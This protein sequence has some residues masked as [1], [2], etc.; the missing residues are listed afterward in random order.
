[1]KISSRVCIAMAMA[2]VPLAVV[3]AEAITI[4]VTSGTSGSYHPSQSY[5]ESRGVDVTVLTA[6][7]LLV[8]SM[9]LNALNVGADGLADVGARIYTS[10]SG[11]LVASRDT[12]VFANGSVTL[13]L[14]ATMAAGHS[15]RVCFF[16]G[17]LGEN[18]DNSATL[19]QPNAFPY[20]DGTGSL[21]INQAY[22]SPVD[23]Y[24]T[25]LNIFAPWI[26]IQATPAI[27]GVG[28]RSPGSGL[29]LVRPASPSPFRSSTSIRFD[30]G[31]GMPV[32]ARVVTLTG[33]VVRGLLGP[34]WCSAG[35]HELKWD[36]RDDQGR[37]APGGVYFVQVRA[38][39][40]VSVR[41]VQLL[42]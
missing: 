38:G 14:T 7:D 39:T 27:S 11:T 6:T 5:N 23:S 20:T 13:H 37:R 8:S 41:R 19:F 42:P 4:D 35:E 25:N 28:G 15:Y 40:Q 10:P 16:C 31:R 22:E 36:G 17:P 26:V 29:C 30:L 33:R 21:R 24:P 2:A 18:E 9:T 12:T 1:M 32:E 34:G 3:P